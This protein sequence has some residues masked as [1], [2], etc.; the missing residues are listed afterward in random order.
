MA[1]DVRGSISFSGQTV[2]NTPTVILQQK[3][4]AIKSNSGTSLVD[5][6]TSLFIFTGF[7]MTVIFAIATGNGDIKL[8]YNTKPYEKNNYLYLSEDVA[9]TA[10]TANSISQMPAS[11]SL[12]TENKIGTSTSPTLSLDLVLP[13]SSQLSL[14]TE[15][16][17]IAS[18]KAI[19]YFTDLGSYT[20]ADILIANSGE[21][22]EEL[23]NNRVSPGATSNITPPTPPPGV[24]QEFWT[25]TVYF[26]KIVQQKYGL[27]ASLT[28]SQMIKESGG[29][30][31]HVGYNLFG[32]KGKGPAGAVKAAT[33][34]VGTD[35]Q[36][37]ETASYFRAYNSFHESIDDYAKL[38]AESP[39]YKKIQHLLRNGNKDPFQYTE[40]LHGIYATNPN[41]TQ[42]LNEIITRYNLTQYDLN[43]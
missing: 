41:Y 23:I 19:D 34:E 15:N 37:Y 25:S 6:L 35:G 11:T 29:G 33:S 42:S 24:D 10:I 18:Q 39:Y 30:K 38:L 22:T 27:P 16:D 4:G 2:A 3:Y 17:S 5:L 8:T 12:L 31:H 21:N 7:I 14:T 20:L 36:R 13:E 32:I 43:T 9:S 40:A 1:F 28:L 26:A